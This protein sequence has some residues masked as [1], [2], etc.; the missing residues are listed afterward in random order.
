MSHTAYR[1][2]G[3]DTDEAEAGLRRLVGRITRT[4]PPPGAFGA[5]QLDIGYF[6]NVIDIGGVGLAI[7]TDGVGSKALIAQMMNRYD[8]IGIDCVA[9]NVNDLIC[10]G[11][12]PVS[13]VDYIAVERVEARILDAIA[14]GLAQGAEEAGISIAGGETA[15][16]ADIVSGFDLA[17]TAVGTVPLDR[18]VTGC[19]LAPGDRI[20]GIESSGIHSNGLTL[21]RKAF[22]K[23]EKPLSLDY[24][25]PRT[26]VT[27]GEAL[28]CPTLIYVREIM[29]MLDKI[30]D[31]KALINITGDGFLNL[32]RV[33]NPSIGFRIDQL[34][35]TPEIF[36]L[37]QNYESVSDAEM[38][39]VFNMGVGFC[40]IVDDSQAN[41]A[42]DILQR[43]HRKAWVIGAVVED[44]TKGVAI[45]QLGLIGHGKRFRA[46]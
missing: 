30:P 4:W 22:F 18:I 31:I 17:G 34:P 45:V 35:P 43:H 26:G 33:H 23:R 25:L 5:V 6:A 3:V 7:S 37:I 16:L 46:Q 1:G 42:L 13:L 10:V 28:L 12:R 24:Q 21:A 41:L 38:F 36:Q 32:A 2:S 9:V 8:T 14:I 15:Q 19:N 39:E 27:L 20:I 11:A 44:E 40:V 29:D